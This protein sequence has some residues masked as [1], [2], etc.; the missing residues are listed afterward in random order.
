MRA[1][2]YIAASGQSSVTPA[3]PNSWIA[4]SIT[5]GRDARRDDLDRGDLEARALLADGV[6]QPRGL[7][8]EQARLLDLDARLSAMRSLHDALVG[9]RLAERDARLRARAHAARAPARPSRSRACSGG[10]GRGRGGPARSRSRRPPR[11]GGSPPGRARSRRASRSDRRRR[12]GRTPAAPRTTVTPGASI[13]T[14]IIDWRRYGSASGSETPMRIANLQRGRRRAAR[15][16]LVRVD[17][18]S[19][20]RRARCGSDVRRVATTRPTARSSRSTSGSRRRAAGAATAPAAA[21][22]RTGRGSP[23]CRCRAP[24]SSS[25]RASSGDAAHDLAQRR[26]VEVGEPGAVRRSSGRKRFQR[27]RSRAPRPSAPP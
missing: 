2:A 24:R 10:C 17:R 6:H 16:P 4:R 20:R 27:P 13:G 5:V 8:R 21:A 1:C 9:E 3:P 7:H 23:C 14:R 25:P 26:V 18:R 11:R 19:R 12:R 22:C 15:Q